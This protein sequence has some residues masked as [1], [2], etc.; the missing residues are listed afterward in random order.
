MAGSPKSV[1]RL[2]LAMP[3]GSFAQTERQLPIK[4][5]TFTEADVNGGG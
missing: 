2:L 4:D 5:R 3:T 1:E